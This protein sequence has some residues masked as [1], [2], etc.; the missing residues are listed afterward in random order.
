VEGQG[1]RTIEVDCLATSGGWS[2]NL[3]LTYHM[4]GRPVWDEAVEGFVPREGAVPGMAV[5]G[6][7]R[8][9][10]STRGCLEDGLRVAQETLSDLGL[11]APDVALPDAE[12]AP[13]ATSPIFVV[14]GRGGS[15]WPS[16]TT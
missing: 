8:G 10:F 14:P 15:S 2:P 1:A 12:D 6:A 11:R 13:R 3:A 5:A 4:G 16:R 9:V 7:A